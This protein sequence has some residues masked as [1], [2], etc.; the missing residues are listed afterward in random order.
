MSKFIDIIHWL[1]ILTILINEVLVQGRTIPS[2]AIIK[3]I[4]VDNDEI[5]DCYDIYRQPSLNYPSLHNHT[6]QLIPSLYPNG[7][8]SDN[9]GTLPLTQTWHKYGSCPDETIP[10]RRKGKN[11]DPTLMRKHRHPKSSPY[12]IQL[13]GV[14]N[15][16]EYA[17]IQV[18]G[19]FQGAQAKINLW[20]PLIELPTEISVSQIWVSAGGEKDTN[21]IEAGWE[22]NPTI[23][24]DDQTRFFIYWTADNY[25]SAGCY[26]LECDGFVH[27]SSSIALGCTF[28]ELSTFK[29]DQ[30]DA[31]FSI[32]KDP[33]SGHWWLQLQG[34]VVGYYPSSL[35][36]E[37][38]KTA[39][40]VF[41]GGEIINR[42]SKGRHTSTQ[43]GSGHFPSEGGL[44]TSSYFNWVQV[45]DLNN[46]MK[47][48]Q[49]IA[50]VVTNPHCYNLTID[51]N[52]HATN[53]YGFYYGGPGYNDK[54]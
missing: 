46:V 38:S 42:K 25:A 15:T 29:G 20:K 47:D 17:A 24:G 50:E 2:A 3:T 8:R 19:N 32:H 35:F 12:K 54:C 44:R 53:G 13:D 33:K 43:M 40:R 22:V 28:T 5:I 21:T 4:K 39:T 48:P 26:N 52:N 37:L 45:V 10:I 16:H 27:I 41:W 14:E 11:Y 49:N 34:I 1:L 18:Q 23:Y 31:T 30:K 51:N 7:M 9:F 6:I 36:T